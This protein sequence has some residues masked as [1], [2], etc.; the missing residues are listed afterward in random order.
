MAVVKTEFIN[1]ASLSYPIS[2]FPQLFGTIGTKTKRKFFEEI[3][4][5][6]GN[7]GD[8]IS[9]EQLVN[10]FR[11]GL[12]TDMPDITYNQA[13]S[14]VQDYLSLYG[15]AALFCKLV[16]AFVDAG[17]NDR[18]TVQK[19]RDAAKKA[20]ELADELE[21][22]N[23]EKKQAYIRQSW[24]EVEKLNAKIQQVSSELNE[25]V[26]ENTIYTT[27]DSDSETPLDPE[28]NC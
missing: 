24:A 21:Q 13:E 20:Q 23:Y 27:E 2:V 6:D 10:M 14:Y 26:S 11:V 18:E 7:G 12:C 9:T 25:V 19:K 8:G 28:P 15:D 5:L 3:A 17:L 16:D 22:I 1:G 4:R